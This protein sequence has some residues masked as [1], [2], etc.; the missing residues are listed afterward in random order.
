M[1]WEKQDH[2]PPSDEGGGSAHADSE[3][4]NTTPQSKIRDFCQPSQ[5][6][7]QGTF[8]IET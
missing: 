4:E 5:R 8:R 7:S 1:E 6:E 3:G 2:M